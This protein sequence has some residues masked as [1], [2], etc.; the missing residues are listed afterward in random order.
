MINPQHR[1]LNLSEVKVDYMPDE[2][3]MRKLIFKATKVH[4]EKTK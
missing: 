4:E 1:I 3:T 2:L